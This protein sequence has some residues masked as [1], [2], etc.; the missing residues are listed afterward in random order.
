MFLCNPNSGK[1]KILKKIEYILTRLKQKFEEVEVKITKS[2]QDL[3]NETKNACL[4]FDVL[5]FAGGDGT[6]NDV[7]NVVKNNNSNIVL[8]YIPTGTCND[9]S[10]SANIPKNIKKALNIICTGTPTFFDGF[11]VNGRFGVYVCASGIFT[12]ASY[13][14]KQKSKRFLGKLGYYFHSF[15]EIFSAKSLDLTFQLD[16][17]PPQTHNS[18]LFLLMNSCSVAGWKLNKNSNVHDGK[19]DF[20]SIETKRKSKKLGFRALLVIAKMFLFGVNSVKKSKLVKFE[21]FSNAKLKTKAKSTINVDGE[22]GGTGEI[23]LEVKKDMFKIFVKR[24]NYGKYKK[25]ME[26]TGKIQK[27]CK[28]FVYRNAF[29]QFFNYFRVFVW[30][31]SF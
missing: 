19:M 7:V 15:K 17:K 16:N 21:K 8:G 6:V 10:K 24:W 23:D 14:T 28:Q 4:N 27:H 12:S 31:T 1:G 9:F 22:N 29:F 13:N 26:C 25:R 30:L 18:V 20:V 3:L 11:C 2:R 5:V